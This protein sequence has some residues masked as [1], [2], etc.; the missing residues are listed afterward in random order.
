MSKKHWWGGLVG[1]IGRH[2]QVIA[3]VAL[4]VGVF[5]TGFSL[6]QSADSVERQLKE[7]KKATSVLIVSDFFTQVGE[8]IVK[9]ASGSDHGA[10]ES[11]LADDLKR[12]IATRSKLLI[13][14]LD[15]PDL[16]GQ[17]I[18]FLGTNGL[19]MLFH[20]QEDFPHIPLT[21]L[22]LR[23]ANLS[24]VI[25]S[26]PVFL[27]VDMEDALLMNATFDN[28]TFSRSNLQC[29]DLRGTTLSDANLLW[30]NLRG[31]MLFG[32]KLHGATIAFSD[33]RGVYVKTN[34]GT[35]VPDD[36]GV[37]RV[38]MF[39]SSLYGSLFDKGVEDELRSLLKSRK[40]LSF[41]D[42][43]QN[44]NVLVTG[45]ADYR[46]EFETV[47]SGYREDA[48]AM[49]AGRTPWSNAYKRKDCAEEA[50]DETAF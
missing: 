40:G 18:R 44:P 10:G 37:A 43:T 3:N 28:A 4:V 9:Q 25:L 35:P 34:A 38:L 12:L 26:Q 22:N 2:H 17:V 29:T 16:T 7:Q 11:P 15:F 41:E 47:Y 48:E 20:R 45:K 14:T 5:L 33:L 46:P 6:N 23:K 27:N 8:H 49:R 19:G 24:G 36:E 21:N 31:A 30:V 1:Y 50:S 42:L 39:A 32:V 13:E